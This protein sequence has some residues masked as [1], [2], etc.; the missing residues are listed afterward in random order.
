MP[1]KQ[2]SNLEFHLA[3]QFQAFQVSKRIG[4]QNKIETTEF[5]KLRYFDPYRIRVSS[6]R[7]IYLNKMFQ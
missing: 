1:K 5:E 7:L 3:I 2:R 4:F 6:L